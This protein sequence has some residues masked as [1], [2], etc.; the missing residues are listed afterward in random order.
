MLASSPVDFGFECQSNQTKDYKIAKLLQKKG[1][2]KWKGYF[3]ADDTIT[4]KIYKTISIEMDTISDLFK[5][6]LIYTYMSYF[7]Y[8]L[9]KTTNYK[10]KNHLCVEKY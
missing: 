3:S 1:H 4:L 6:F 9:L 2:D 7:Q 10:K 5:Y 8:Y